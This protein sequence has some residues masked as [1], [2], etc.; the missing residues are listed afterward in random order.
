MIIRTTTITTGGIDWDEE[1]S[2]SEVRPASPMRFLYWKPPDH[3][4][5]FDMI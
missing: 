1:Q 3:L 4:L 2:D 5:A